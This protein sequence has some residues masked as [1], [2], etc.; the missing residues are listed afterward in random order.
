M[1]ILGNVIG[2]R[3]LQWANREGAVRVEIGEPA[4]RL[5]RGDFVCPY[6]IV[7]IGDDQVLG[8]YGVDSIQ[9]LWIAFMFIG[10]RLARFPE[11]RLDDATD[12]GFP[13]PPVH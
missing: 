2:Q 8:A 9:A 7:G 4:A 1:L 13:L 6:R 11:L 5:E 10:S 12:L 3:T